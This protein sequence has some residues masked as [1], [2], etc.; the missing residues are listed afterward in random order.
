MKYTPKIE[1]TA[2]A[3][4]SLEAMDRH[5]NQQVSLYGDVVCVN[6]INKKGGELNLGMAYQG[7]I[8]QLK[9]TKP[10]TYEWFDFHHECRKMKYENLSKLMHNVG[11]QF[12]KYAQSISSS[13][14]YCYYY[15]YYYYYYYYYYDY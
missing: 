10:L 14:Y 11:T 13:F 15:S 7:G 12:Q 4:Q 1:F 8:E 2:P 6:L 5:F 3:A 9:A